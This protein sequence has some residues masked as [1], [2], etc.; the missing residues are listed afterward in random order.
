[1]LSQT[2]NKLEGHF[3]QL[4]RDRVPLGYPVY[5]FEHGLE[6]DEINSIRQALCADLVRTGRVEPG[7]WLLWAVVAAEIGYTY[8]GDEY[9][10]SFKSQ[11]PEWF[12][13]S[14][15]EAVREWFVDFTRRFN[16][17]QPAGRWANHFS[18]IA[19]PITHSILPRYLQS[20]FAQH[21]YDL[22]HDL[23]AN[24]NASIDQIGQLLGNQYHGASARFEN[25]L[26]QTALTARLVLALRDEDEQGSVTPI[27][28]PTLA[29][30]VRDLE[31]KGSS[32]GYLH[33]ARRVLRDARLRARSGLGSQMQR[34]SSRS[35]SPETVATVP[36]G[37]KLTARRT[38]DETWTI[39]AALPNFA[40]L[41]AQTGVTSATLDK[42]RL[43]FADRPDG[44]MP[45]RALL[46]YSDSNHPL[47]ALP[48]PLSD[49]VIQS[50]GSAEPVNALTSQLKILSQAPWLLR[51]HEDGV[52]RQVLGNHVR[53]AEDYIVITSSA[54]APDILSALSLRET[55]CATSGV[56]LYQIRTPNVASPQFIQAL[57]KLSF[58]Y[59]LQAQVKPFGL[60]PRWDDA[61]ACSAWL[62]NEEILLHLSADFH[63]AE[64]IV[65]VNGSGKTRVAVS[66]KQDVLISL[67]TPPLGRYAVEIAATA[68]SDGSTGKGL[69]Q[70]SPE[71]LFVEVRSPVPWRQDVKMQ[72]G[73]RVVLEPSDATFDDLLEKRASLSVQGPA[74]RSATVEVRLYDVSGHVFDT[75]EI[76]RLELPTKDAFMARV[77]EKLARDP[78]LSEKIQSAPRVELAF[79]A[80]ELG[81]VTFSF[82]HKVPPLR[83]KFA[84]DDGRYV[85]RLVDEAGVAANTSIGRYDMQVPDRRSNIQP[86][87]CVLGVEVDPPGSLFVA[88]HDGHFYAAFA[89]VPPRERMTTFLD[90]ATNVA[91]SVPGGSSR[92]ITRLLAILR[93]WRRGRPL[94]SVAAI[95]KA[96][97]LGVVERQI[98]RLV[99]GGRWADRARRYR[100]GDGRLEDLQ[101]EVGGSP[102][103]ASRMRTTNWT[104]HSDSERAKAEFFRLANT[105]GV[106][107]DKTI[108]D[109]ALR[110]AFHPTS[111]RL[112]DPTKNAHNFEQLGTKSILARGAYFAKLTSD[113]RFNS[114]PQTETGVLK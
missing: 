43:R 96:E 102:G 13:H 100:D 14:N 109:L 91:L 17:F 29:R 86:D 111:I 74:D 85:M 22:R 2:Q 99:C 56:L 106:S 18:I 7:Y 47:L 45:G 77:I 75:T 35:S 57:S 114:T 33:D 39:C 113:L 16:G 28:R 98:E 38:Q 110:L 108:C 48:S 31:R 25:F 40:A 105:Y 36:P 92:N 83:W 58:G 66:E 61:N 23:A 67:G 21:L 52:A 53:T 42:T 80:D 41:M 60:V 68:V 71:T 54:V 3:Q 24:E 84:R 51:V 49:P 78:I 76:G 88:T 107:D 87:S 82:P 103:F 65:T 73:L 72:T 90:L 32:R 11:V 4:S 101:G 94:G 10:H 34:G 26:Q 9:W 64:F 69:R 30:I 5:A 1:M 81:A 79:V 8:D 55:A 112:N 46:S 62:P 97:V 6:S 95:R 19:W 50:R 89:S 15:R 12:T 44:W 59:A 70:I 104:W 20:P 63:V 27:Y 37:I 93:L